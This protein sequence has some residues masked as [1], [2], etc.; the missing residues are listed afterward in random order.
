MDEVLYVIGSGYEKADNDFGE[1]QP[2]AEI[3]IE[4]NIR[5]NKEL[6]KNQFKFLVLLSSRK[7]RMEK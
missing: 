6:G 5:I 1:N 3:I 4:N 2:I 7:R